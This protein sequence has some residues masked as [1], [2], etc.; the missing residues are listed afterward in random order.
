MKAADAM[1]PFAVPLAVKDGRHREGNAL[2]HGLPDLPGPVTCRRDP[3][4]VYASE[5]LAQ[6][7]RQL[8]A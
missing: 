6:T 2:G 4:A 7:L 3:Q 1:R 5:S 8:R